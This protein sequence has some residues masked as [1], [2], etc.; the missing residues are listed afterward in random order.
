[1]Y[2]SIAFQKFKNI[3]ENFFKK[4]KGIYKKTADYIY[5]RKK[6]AEYE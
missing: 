3:I 5:V 1:M 2:Y 4:I 6:G